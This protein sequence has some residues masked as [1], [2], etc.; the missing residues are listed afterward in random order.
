MFILLQ[1]H[2]SYLILQPLLLCSY[3]Y[4]LQV[5]AQNWTIFDVTARVQ[6]E[7][8][9]S[10]LTLRVSGYLSYRKKKIKLPRYV[11]WHCHS[12]VATIKKPTH[13]FIY[14]GF[15]SSIYILFHNT[16]FNIIIGPLPSFTYSLI[17]CHSLV[18]SVC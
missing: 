5:P 9:G 18:F 15:P 6:V 14:L 11:L 1:V 8:R 10:S 2:I 7:G 3:M 13:V 12:I 4:T 16:S 17:K